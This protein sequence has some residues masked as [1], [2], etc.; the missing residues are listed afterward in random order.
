MEK[1]VLFDIDGTL[2][3]TGG[4]G[5]RALDMAFHDL[6][7]IMDAFKGV[8]M[9]GRTDIGI[10]KE[11]LKLHGIGVR[12]GEVEKVAE[13]YIS[14]LGREINNPDRKVKPGVISVLERLRMDEV[15]IGLLTGNIEK[16][17]RIKLGALGLNEYFPT[18]AFGNDH[19]DRDMLLPI[20]LKRF[21]ELGVV[22][23]P[24]NCIVVGDTPRDVRCSRVHGASCI[25]VA[26]GPYRAEVLESAGADLVL[27][28]L[29]ERG[30][31][32]NFI[33][34]ENGGESQ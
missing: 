4:A 29:A 26:T 30:P 20:A 31:F 22:V 8:K 7:G 23:S 34:G 6:Y 9:A 25:G 2:I 24:E 1:L 13:R 5:L 33:N 19:E 12:D 17:A 21:S 15:P 16:G 10:I 18:G 14:F 27:E 11:G 28:S 32:F 3:D